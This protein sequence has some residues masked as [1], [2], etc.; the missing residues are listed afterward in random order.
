ME[1]GPAP[2]Y[3][4]I[5][6]RRIAA[7]RLDLKQSIIDGVVAALVPPGHVTA[8]DEPWL[9]LCLDEA[10]VNAMLHGNEGDPGL[11]IDVV[12]GLDSDR[13]YVQIADCGTGFA[14]EHLPRID[15]EE[16]LAAEHG[17]GVK[18]MAD[19]LDDLTWFRHGAVV[20]MGRRRSDISVSEARAS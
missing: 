5:I 11:D 4:D 1:T 9:C 3:A 2:E 13:W 17:R 10:V 16:A 14:I 7:S 20:R 8:E 12:V 18:L 19:W 15:T 6:F